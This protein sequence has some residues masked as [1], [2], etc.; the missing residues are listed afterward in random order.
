MTDAELYDYLRERFGFGAW[1]EA[2]STIPWWKFRG[3]GIGQLKAMK[4]KRGATDVQLVAAADYAIAHSKPVTELYQLF[5]LIPEAMA[6][7]RREE[8]T[9]AVARHATEIELAIGEAMLA[10][11]DEWVER[12]LRASPAE[13]ETVINQWRN[14]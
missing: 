11:E 13:A 1:D 14:R 6:W 4:R 3:I 2:I 7:R 9:A 10:G 5:A 12:L 8:K